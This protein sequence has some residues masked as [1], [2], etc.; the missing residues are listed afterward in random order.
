ML[1]KNLKFR[2]FLYLSCLYLDK[3]ITGIEKD[4]EHTFS[5]NIEI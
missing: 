1:L 5:G 4:L 2:K 3:L